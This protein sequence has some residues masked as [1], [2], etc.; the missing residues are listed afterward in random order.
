MYQ[1]R[2]VV[3]LRVSKAAGGRRVDPTQMEEDMSL[4]ATS[5]AP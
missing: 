1:E 4:T 2:R 3:L 5:S